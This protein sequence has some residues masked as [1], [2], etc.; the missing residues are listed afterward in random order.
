MLRIKVK[1]GKITG[2][3]GARLRDVFPPKVAKLK[4]SRFK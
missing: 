1:S 3:V 4:E 2:V